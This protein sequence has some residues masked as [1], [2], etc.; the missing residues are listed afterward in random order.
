VL[1]KCEQNWLEVGKVIDVG[2]VYLQA[3]APVK[4]GKYLTIINAFTY[5]LNNQ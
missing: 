4:T 3:S 1:E 2:K 5:K